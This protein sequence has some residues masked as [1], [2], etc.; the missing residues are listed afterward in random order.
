MF[1]EK[2]LALILAGGRGGR[3]GLLTDD[4]AKPVMPFGGSYRL[5]DFA[6]SNCVNS[7]I[8]DVWVVEQYE[9]HSLN[10][11]LSNGRPWDLDRTYGGLQVLPPFENDSD[12]DGFAE[13]N[14]DAIYRHVDF[15]SE[16]NPDILLVLSADH[17]YK[18]DFRDAIKTHLEKKASV[19]MVTTRLPKGE[20]A[21]RFGVVEADKNGRIVKFDYKPDQ[22]ESDL[23]TTE[24]FVYD[25]RTLIKTL[26]HLNEKNEK[27]K[28][29][30]HELLPHL[31]AEGNAFDHRLVGYW[32]DVGTIESYWQTQMDLLDEKERLFF[33][34]D[35]WKILTLSAQRVP[36]FI[37]KS[38]DVTNS[39]ISSGSR[40]SGAV[41]RSVLSAGVTI[42]R[43][44]EV[45]DSIVL[46]NGTIEKGVKIKRV[47]V[48][49]GVKVN[50]EKALKI[51]AARGKNKSAII[52]VGK[53]KVQNARD[54][55][56]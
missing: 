9:L 20:S 22:P 33:D 50:R 49:T 24:I 44:A 39:L 55:E 48:D 4:K 52:V 16:F 42:E 11:H 3:L 37:Y 18:M 46:P 25:A 21:S 41:S 26:K 56:N 1:K 28:D 43:G 38:A 12:K 2:V 29:Y 40:I 5:I 35:D 7:Q 13:G 31:V 47:I 23:I 54:V 6:L 32:R 34:D 17:V 30:G 27:I 8:S 36:A 53:R 51:E 15:I 19:T 10:E 45:A 14:A